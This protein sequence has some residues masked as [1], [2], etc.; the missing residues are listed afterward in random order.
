M[1]M[2]TGCFGLL[3]TA[4]RLTPSATGVGSHRGL[5]LA[6]CQMLDRTGVP[7]P[8]CGMTTSFTWFAR[9]HVAASAYVQPMGML[10][11]AM[12]ACGVWVGGYVAW[13]GRPVHRLVYTLPTRGLL[14]ALLALGIAGWGW[15]ILLRFQGLDGW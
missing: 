11:A 5:G 12:A 9:G 10:L 14:I 4:A 8:S 3:L 7:C 2:A 13:T 6:S 15:K 1:V